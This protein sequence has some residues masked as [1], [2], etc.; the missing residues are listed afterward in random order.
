M[1]Y[2]NFINKI[3]ELGR[4]NGIEEN[5]MGFENYKENNNNNNNNN[6]NLLIIS[7]NKN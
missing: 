3:I 2:T 4:K 5:K 6:T 7:V 1:K